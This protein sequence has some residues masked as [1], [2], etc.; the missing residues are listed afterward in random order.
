MV[1]LFLKEAKNIYKWWENKPQNS[2]QVTSDT[3][4][5]LPFT[6][7]ILD[8]SWKNHTVTANWNN[9]SFT[10]N[11][12][13]AA[14]MLLNNWWGTTYFSVD[15]T[16]V[17][18]QQNQPRTWAYKISE[19]VPMN[20]SW[21]WV[22]VFAYNRQVKVCWITQSTNATSADNY[23]LPWN[24]E[25]YGT[26][27]TRTAVSPTAAKA[28][29]NDVHSVVFTWD[30]VSELKQYLDWTL[31]NTVAVSWTTSQSSDYCYI[32]RDAYDSWS[33]RYLQAKVSHVV[34]ENW[35]WPQ[36]RINAYGNIGKYLFN[37]DFTT[38]SASDITSLWFL[39]YW[40][41]YWLQLDTTNNKWLHWANYVTDSPAG[42]EIPCW[43][44]TWKTV[45]FSIEWD[46]WTY[47]RWWWWDI[48]IKRFPSAPSWRY[49]YDNMDSINLS[50]FP[51]YASWQY[52]WMGTWW[53]SIYDWS[54][55]N[56]NW[57]QAWTVY[58]WNYSTP[59]FNLTI[60]NWIWKAEWS[61]NFNT[62]TYTVTCT[63]EVGWDTS[64]WTF[65]R[66]FTN[67]T[68]AEQTLIDTLLASNSLY[69]TINNGRWYWNS[70]ND[71]NYVKSASIS[72]N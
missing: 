40:E 30:W 12:D 20:S 58:M 39:N 55:T 70:S 52:S 27:M 62:M 60:W 48:N 72:I 45:T 50:S 65:T 9:Y 49:K 37:L 53:I 51:F 61:F 35:V 22:S 5:Y 68:S 3:I 34:Y 57:D 42:I 33:W 19:W 29:D 4:L 23:N 13:W 31:I 24:I 21:A 56:I 16:D 14:C 69:I 64:T 10:T 66:T 17:R 63:T 25:L 43:A 47:T 1:T 54:W 26:T 18:F 8:H 15:W 44:L 6:E 11:S 32:F 46:V 36:W 41:D 59:N 67:L 71:L 28:S 2:W 7:D 38:C